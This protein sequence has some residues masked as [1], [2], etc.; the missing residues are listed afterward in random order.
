M[1]HDKPHWPK[2]I[3]SGCF[4]SGHQGHGANLGWVLVAGVAA[5]EDSGMRPVGISLPSVQIAVTIAQ[6]M[7][8]AITQTI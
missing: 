7:L 2:A 8:E 5:W 4:V 3:F 1:P 6:G